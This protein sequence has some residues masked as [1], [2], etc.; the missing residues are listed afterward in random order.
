MEE[1]LN[2][3]ACLKRD[4]L[5]GYLD[6][7]LSADQRFD[8]ENHL[9]DCPLCEAALAGFA[10]ADPQLSEEHLTQIEAAIPS[11]STTQS[12]KKESTTAARVKPLRRRNWLA[13]AAAIGLLVLSAALYQQYAPKSPEQ[14]YAQVFQIYESPYT[15]SRNNDLNNA[16][17][18]AGLEAYQQNDFNRAIPLLE[19]ATAQNDPSFI[20]HLHAGLSYMQIGDF[21]KA[22]NYLTTT[23]INSA[24]FYG[25]ATWYLALIKL[26]ENKLTATRELLLQIKANELEYYTKAQNL[27]KELN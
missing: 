22:E 7:S 9:L 18:D 13:A 21:L 11:I 14:I 4:E 19:T 23:R 1:L 12:P 26:Q 24:D 3:R 27:L 25:P 16:P 2:A 17:F 10:N 6:N 5:Q 8:I 20:A 15:G